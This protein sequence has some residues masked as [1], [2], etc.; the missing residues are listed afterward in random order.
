MVVFL[1]AGFK[2]E[3]KHLLDVS[4]INCQKKK[5]RVNHILPDILEW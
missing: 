3:K 2:E 4:T 1:F 5:I